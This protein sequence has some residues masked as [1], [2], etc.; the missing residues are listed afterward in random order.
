MLSDEALMSAVGKG[1]NQSFEVIVR[2]HGRLAWSIAFRFLGH[3]EE[4]EDIVQDAFVKILGAASNYRPRAS[5]Q[6]YLYH[7][8]SRL[9][10]DAAAKKRPKT[11]PEGDEP[12]A[13]LGTPLDLLVER[14]R[15]DHIHMALEGLSPNRRMAIILRHYEDLSYAEIAQAMGKSPKA[16]ERLLATARA[17]LASF[18]GPVKE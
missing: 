8:V 15:K 2:R 9:C 11:L 7:V 16:V 3:A 12:Q 4:A 13:P 10:L 6:T 18:L 1:D 5:F 14:D 17:S